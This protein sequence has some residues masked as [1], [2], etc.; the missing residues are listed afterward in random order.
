MHLR[1]KDTDPS[2]SELDD[3]DTQEHERPPVTFR[4][5]HAL[6]ILGVLM[7]L[8]LGTVMFAQVAC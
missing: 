3:A 7:A 4:E 5:R 8:S 2:E 1:T 6:K